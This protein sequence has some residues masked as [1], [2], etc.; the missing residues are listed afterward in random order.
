[1][2]IMFLDSN[3]YFSHFAKGTRDVI[4]TEDVE[5]ALCIPPF[6][7]ELVVAWLH[8]NG[9]PDASVSKQKI[10]RDSLGIPRVFGD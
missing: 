10:E 9:W 7:A 6:L 5:M 2:P 8:E 1:M 4:G 3:Q